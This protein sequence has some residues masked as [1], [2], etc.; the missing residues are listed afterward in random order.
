MS[1]TEDEIIESWSS[2]QAPVVSVCTITYNHVNFIRQTLDSILDQITSF[3]IEVLVHD[4]AST[5]GTTDLVLDYAE[6][7]PTIVRP[8]IQSKN[9]YS[10][11]GG[12]IAPRFVYP[13]ARGKYIALCEGD[14]YWGDNMKLEKQVKFL[15]SNPDFV[16][17]YAVAKAFNASGELERDFGGAIRDLSSKELRLGTP[18][19][20]LTACFRN[21]IRDIHPDLLSAR[22]GDQ[23]QW[24]LLSAFGKGKFLSNVGP[25]YYRVHDGGTHSMISVEK[26]VERALITSNALMAF[27]SATGDKESSNFFLRKSFFLTRRLVGWKELIRFWIE[28]K[29]P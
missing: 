3:P 1:R 25:S 26:K 9:Q 13:S 17:T 23:V 12:L 10:S 22:I 4:D 28:Q 20:T 19:N 11:T 8:I 2:R 5:D 24:S 14:D 18:I 16:I 15:D 27:Y 7:Y 6:R 29:L 21:V